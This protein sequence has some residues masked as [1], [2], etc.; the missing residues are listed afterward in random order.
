MRA[1]TLFA[2]IIAVTCATAAAETPE[3]IFKRVSPSVVVVESLDAKGSVLSLGSGVI[4]APLKPWD[5]DWRVPPMPG[6][7]YKVLG[8][9]VVTNRH[10]IE[11]GMTFR[12][13]QNGKA[14]PAKL[15]RV[16]PNHDL[17]EL[18]VD[19]LTAP[20]VQVRNSSTLAV[21]EKVYAIGA[22]EGLE[23][24]IS[25][26]LISGLRDFDRER[27]IQTS[28]AISPGSSGGGLFDARARLVGITSF[29]LKEGQSLNFALPAEWTLALNKQP[30]ETATA[31]RQNSPEFQALPWSTL[32]GRNLEAG[33]YGPAAYDYQQV[34]LLKPGDAEAWCLLGHA[35][36]VLEQYGN[37]ARAER[38]SIRLKPDDQ[39]AWDYLG[40]AYAGLGQNGDAVRAEQ[41]AIRLKPD[42]GTAWYNLGWAYS[43][44]GQ[45][46]KQLSAEEQAVHL[47]PDDAYFWYDLGLAYGALGQQSEVLKVYTKLK[48]LDPKMAREFSESRFCREVPVPCRWTQR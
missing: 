45:Y 6:S 3:Q 39:E 9:V 16:D 12:V 34:V 48:T 13:E 7:V 47:R 2:I 27:V 30:L 24:T 22:P 4:I 33:K 17:A 28:A 26:G 46:D 43:L 29:Y 20:P 37:A 44:L 19:R 36:N 5:L 23:L 8:S 35:Y 25:E 15:I 14:W 41:Q 31:A 38:E 21:G 42:D 18:S 1:A 10:V 32:G 11:D 40:V